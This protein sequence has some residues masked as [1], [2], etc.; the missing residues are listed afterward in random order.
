MSNHEFKAENLPDPRTGIRLGPYNGVRVTHIPTGTYVD[1]DT[2][3]SQHKNRDKALEM[4]R[5]LIAK[6]RPNG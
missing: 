2:E 4:L 5:R 3:R 1:C 6:D